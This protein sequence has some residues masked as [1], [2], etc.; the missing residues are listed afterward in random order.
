M[1]P[2]HFPKPEQKEEPRP[3]AETIEAEAKDFIE[4]HYSEKALNGPNKKTYKSRRN[5]MLVR[6][7]E[8][9]DPLTFQHMPP[10]E[11]FKGWKPEDFEKLLSII[12]KYERHHP[13]FD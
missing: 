8:L 12:K 3:A 13:A 11:R 6:Y 1:S 7:Q 4:D 9:T 5:A 2:E 10:S